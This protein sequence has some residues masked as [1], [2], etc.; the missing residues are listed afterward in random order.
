MHDKEHNVE[1]YDNRNARIALLNRWLIL[2]CKAFDIR[3]GLFYIAF[4]LSFFFFACR[5]W[6]FVVVLYSSVLNSFFSLPRLYFESRA[7][8][9]MTLNPKRNVQNII[10][11]FFFLLLL[12]LYSSVMSVCQLADWF[13][14]SFRVQSH[15]TLSHFEIIIFYSIFK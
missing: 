15:C 8:V 13:V 2:L 12:F 10:L 14:F 7:I 6:F 1:T 3:F 9:V 4:C 11:F 5:C